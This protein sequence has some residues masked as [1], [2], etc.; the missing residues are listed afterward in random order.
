MFHLW[1]THWWWNSIKAKEAASS[2]LKRWHVFTF[3]G[4]WKGQQWSSCFPLRVLGRLWQDCMGRIKPLWNS[5]KLFWS[6]QWDCCAGLCA[7]SL[8][9]N[10][11]QRNMRDSR[12]EKK[13]IILKN[14]SQQ[15]PLICFSSIS[16]IHW[17]TVVTIIARKVLS[18]T[19]SKVAFTVTNQ[20][21]KASEGFSSFFS[22]PRFGGVPV[23]VGKAGEWRQVASCSCGDNQEMGQGKSFVSSLSNS[24]LSLNVWLH[25]WVD[26][27]V[28][29]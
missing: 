15:S 3:L 10:W 22:F 7:V 1:E 26:L 29:K 17:D 5:K 2:I 6:W 11:N 27:H 28:K 14:S 12:A 19:C 25:Y 9:R 8:E 23:Q 24:T 21:Q 16:G 13:I 18:S 20:S 4:V